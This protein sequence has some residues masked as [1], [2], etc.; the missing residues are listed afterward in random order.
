MPKRNLAWILVVVMI[1]LLMWQLPQTI[2]RRDSVSQAFGPLVDARAQIRRRYVHDVSDD[3]LISAAVGGGVQAMIDRLGD[4]YARYM[5]QAQYDR[6]QKRTEGIIGGI[7][8]D[9]ASTERGLE[10]LSVQR[11]SP[12]HHADIRPAD[13][14]T[15]IDDRS[16]IGLPLTDAVNGYLNGPPGT[17]VALTVVT[18]EPAASGSDGRTRRVELR[19]AEIELDPVRGWY[20]APDGGWHFMLDEELGIACI[21]LARFSANSAG[22]IDEVT[23]RLLRENLRGLILDLRDNP[24]GLR[25]SALDIADRFLDEGLIVRIRG[26]GSDAKQWFARRNGTYPPI[27]LAIL[28]NQSTAS[29]AEIVAGALKDHQRAVLFGERSYGKGSVQEVIPLAPGSGA[30]KITTAYY[31]LPSGQCV[32]RTRETVESG[33]WG[34]APHHPVSLTPQ[35]RQACLAAWRELGRADPGRNTTQPTTAAARSTLDREKRRR[36]AETLL[37]ADIQ[38]EKALDHLRQTLTPTAQ[39]PESQRAAPERSAI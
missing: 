16:T 8:V 13:L 23:D 15:E 12:A 18:I 29:A 5:N 21:R 9:V 11:N 4:P 30:I 32:Q 17:H 37:D 24:G 28:I 26:R 34:V 36:A 31:F 1:A 10:V 6:F 14:I 39:R 22:R 19:R 38:L 7:G 20:R 25:D 35:Q 2:A 27:P 3:Q 33:T